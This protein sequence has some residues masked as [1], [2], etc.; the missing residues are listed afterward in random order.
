MPYIDLRLPAKLAWQKTEDALQIECARFGKKALYNTNEPQVFVHCPNGGRRSQREASKLKMMGVCAGFPDVF[1]PLRSGEY[2]GLYVE[3]KKAGGA[4][5]PEQKAF[6]NTATEE[7]YLA[8]VVNDL[9]T[10]KA[11]FTAYLEDRHHA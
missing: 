1:L 11:V 4:P 9:D 3:L 7:G 10:F 8:V 6:L 5:K 2:A